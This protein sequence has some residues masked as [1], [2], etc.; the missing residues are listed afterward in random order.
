MVPLSAQDVCFNGG[1]SFS[2]GC[3]G[4]QVTDP[5]KYLQKGGGGAVSG[6]QFNGTGPFGSGY[7]SDFSMPHCHHHGPQGDDPFPA[8][9]DPGCKSQTTPVG[10]SVCDGTA[11]EPHHD[12]EADRYY[13]DG[14]IVTANGEAS[15]QRAVM[16]G[17]PME[18]SF[19]VFED[20]ENY[21]GGIYHHVTGKMSGGHAVKLIGW[22]VEDGVK[23][24]TIANSWNKYWGEKGNF[25]I[26][27]GVDEGGIENGAIAS[28]HR[29]KWSRVGDD[30]GVGGP[31]D[32]P[33]GYSL[34]GSI[35]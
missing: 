4:G 9:G 12:F 3:N 22:G 29:A 11:V 1:G 6:G 33:M 13:F 17:G 5:W 20:F 32:N 2:Q 30:A 16:A 23:Y 26:L 35:L 19:T 34:K 18:V 7:C 15:I 27:R 24:W 8:E 14:R 31:I 25:R 28:C 21:S 10:P